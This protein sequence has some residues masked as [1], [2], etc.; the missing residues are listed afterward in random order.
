MEKSNGVAKKEN[1]YNQ[2]N[3]VIKQIFITTKVSLDYDGVLSTDK[4]KEL[5]K[6]L[7]SEGKS[8]SII[9]AR[10]SVDGMLSTAEEVGIAKN[11]IHATGSNKSK[12]E[13]VKELNIST[14]YDNNTDVIA[15]LPGIGK[16]FK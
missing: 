13:K 4:G 16:L 12:V 6:R 3:K 2:K 15:Q 1:V 8:V 7:I 5:A 11:Q 9:S 14:H 10:D